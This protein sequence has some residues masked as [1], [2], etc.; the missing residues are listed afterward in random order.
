MRQ[1]GVYN[2]E[3]AY[4]AL[5]EAELFDWGLK[6]TEEKRKQR[7]YVERQGSTVSRDDN[8]ITRETISEWMKTPEGRAKYERNRDKIL[9]LMQEGAL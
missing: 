3:V 1:N 7:P 4:K 2:P 6:K 8:T 9:K 5:H